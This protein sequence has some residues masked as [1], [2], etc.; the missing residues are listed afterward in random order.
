MSMVTTCV[1]LGVGDR[2]EVPPA[3]AGG[4]GDAQPNIKP[5][6]SIAVSSKTSFLMT[7]SS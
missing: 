2:V 6:I 4:F 5:Q 7:S 3:G 1:A